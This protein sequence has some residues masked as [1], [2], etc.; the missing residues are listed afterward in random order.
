MI[1]LKSL[2]RINTALLKKDRRLIKTR[3][4]Q[5]HHKYQSNNWSRM[6][7]TMKENTQ[8]KFLTLLTFNRMSLIINLKI[9]HSTVLSK[10]FK[11]YKKPIKTC[12]QFKLIILQILK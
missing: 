1:K 6:E 9:P 10:R 5:N 11:N 8:M 3:W 7:M 12:H 2:K 4:R